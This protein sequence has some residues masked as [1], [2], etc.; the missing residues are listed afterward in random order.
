ML[1][2]LA[3]LLLA[4]APADTPPH[5]VA[6]AE[7]PRTVQANVREHHGG[8]IRLLDVDARP[9]APAIPAPAALRGARERSPRRTAAIGALA[10]AAAGTVVFL[11]TMGDGCGETGSMCGLGI[12]V[13][14]GGGAVVGGVVGWI[15]GA[16]DR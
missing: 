16:V 13:F 1:T 6:L 10:G 5:T 12:P 2:P 3:L 4:A 7:P 11:A 8:P 9:L 15:V 14:V